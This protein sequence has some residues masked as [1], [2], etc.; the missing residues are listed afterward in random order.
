MN[1]MEYLILILIIGNIFGTFT[2]KIAKAKNLNERNWF[3]AGFF[4]TI[5]ALI[6]VIG[7]P[8]NKP[9]EESESKAK[10]VE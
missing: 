7:M 6:A 5:I 8:A 2:S 3:A 4:L 1:F 10:S 9:N